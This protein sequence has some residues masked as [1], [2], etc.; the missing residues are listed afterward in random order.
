MDT[1]IKG[2]KRRNGGAKG[3]IVESTELSWRATANS[4]RRV[5]MEGQSRKI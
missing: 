1:T 5:D 3:E 4:A 2:D